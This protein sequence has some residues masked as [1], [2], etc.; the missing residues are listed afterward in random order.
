MSDLT[1]LTEVHGGLLPRDSI[2]HRYQLHGRSLPCAIAFKSVD[3]HLMHEPTG[4]ILLTHQRRDLIE[5]AGEALSNLDTPVLFDSHDKHLLLHSLPERL[6]S[7]LWELRQLGPRKEPIPFSAFKGG[8]KRGEQAYYIVVQISGFP[9]PVPSLRVGR[10]IRPP[11]T[12]QRPR[13]ALRNET[14]TYWLDHI[15]SGCLV[16]TFAT[17]KVGEQV[18]KQ[19]YHFVGSKESFD[20]NQRE[21]AVSEL[22]ES[23]R[24]YVASHSLATTF[25]N[26]TEWG[27]FHGT[28]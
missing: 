20:S 16:G 26:F 22:P 15:P 11:I 9:D 10:V 8:A 14:G 2:L 17:K 24:L 19:M 6:A 18:A 21:I 28:K 13:L 3:Y 12:G 23:F 7:W 1:T 5:L 25:K 27:E 4:V